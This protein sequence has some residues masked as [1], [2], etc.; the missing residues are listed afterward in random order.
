MADPI[1]LVS[2]VGK[3][4]SGKTTLIVALASEYARRGRVV[5][6]LKHGTHPAKLDQEGTDTW[7]HMHEGSAERVLI[8]SSGYRALI[9]RLEEEEDPTTLARRYMLGTDIVIAEGFTKHP[10]PKI[11]VY[12]RDAHAEPHY[13]STHPNADQWFA[14]VTDHKTTGY[15]FP[16]FHLSDTAW[17]VTLS[18]LAWGKA[19]IIE[20]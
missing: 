8:E 13:A 14:M 5:G 11:E 1:R 10:I 6:T 4:N 15:P 18:K 20:D 9:Q 3:K 19:M 17:L 2:V 12:R 7:R 16:T